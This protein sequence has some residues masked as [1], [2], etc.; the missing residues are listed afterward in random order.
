[1]TEAFFTHVC[2]HLSN[3]L[4]LQALLIVV[5]TCFIEDPARCAV[6]LLV[7]AGHVGW[8]LS[9]VSMTI[10]GMAGDIGLYVIGRY[11]TLFLIRRRWVDAARLE[12]MEE[13]FNRH[14][15]KAVLIA[16]FIPGARMIAY[17]SAG[18]VRYPVPRFLLLLLVA[19]MIQ[20]LIFLKIADFIAAH[21]LPYLRD[22]RLQLAV[23]VAIVLALVLAHRAITRRTKKKGFT[24]KP[25]PATAGTPQ[26]ER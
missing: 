10:G 22:T 4:W 18:A 15:V 23:F 6:G 9:F 5:G 1:V 14:A 19:A 17:I 25:E 12:W 8:W 3:H 20:S 21:I 16:R 7:A 26:A 13:S 24:L 11:A 2:E